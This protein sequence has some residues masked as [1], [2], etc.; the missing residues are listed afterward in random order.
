MTRRGGPIA[1]RIDRVAT[2]IGEAIVVVDGDDRLRVLDWTDR[3]PYTQRLLDLQCGRGKYALTR[4]RDPGGVASALRRYFRGDLAAIDGIAV[5][6]GGTVFQRKAW[7]TLRRIACGTTVSY[8]ELARRI[9]KPKA[10]RAAGTANGRNPI[11]I[12]VPCHRVIG[13]N[14][15]LTGYG[16]GLHR[17]EWLLKHE[18]AALL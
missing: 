6:T 10:I 11:G 12:V 18:G 5:E 13:S 14:G 7:R 3:E 16:G 2:P 17:K 8:A 1:L 4:A 15:T 9:G